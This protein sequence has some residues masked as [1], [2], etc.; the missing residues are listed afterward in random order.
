MIFDVLVKSLGS[1]IYTFNV[2][3]LANKFDLMVWIPVD[4]GSNDTIQ[5]SVPYS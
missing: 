1:P 2:A 3:D 5:L 4:S